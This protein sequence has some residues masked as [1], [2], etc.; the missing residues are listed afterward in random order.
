MRATRPAATRNI[1]AVTTNIVST[2]VVATTSPPMAGPMRKARLSIVL[3]APLAAV[4]SAGCGSARAAR[5]LG[6]P[7]TTRRAGPGSRAR[8]RPTRGR[9]PAA[10]RPPPRRA[11]TDQG[12]HEQHALARKRVDERG[13]EGVATAISASRTPA[14]R[15]TLGALALAV[16][17]DGHRGQVL[18]VAHERCGEGG[19]HAAQRRLPEDRTQRSPG[20]A[21]R[22]AARPA[23][24]VGGP[25]SPPP[26]QPLRPRDIRPSMIQGAWAAP[27]TARSSH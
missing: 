11:P 18:L 4:S 3:E 14:H 26:Q 9:R 20:V 5:R 22:G 8:G 25:G 24:S 16:G 23:L 15:A 7:K 21:E 10:P 13:P 27:R 6:G 12:G 17:P 1:T 19:L 2:L